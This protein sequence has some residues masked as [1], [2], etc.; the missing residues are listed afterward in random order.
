M[1]TILISGGGGY[2]GTQ[3]SQFLLKKHKVIIFDKFYFPWILK[4]KKKIKNN[5]N[6]SFIKKNISSAKL[7]DFK[8]VD[9]VCDLNGISNDPSSEL[10]PKH[11]WKLNFN[12]RVNFAKLSKKAKIKRYI[13]NSTCSVYGF[14]N[15]KVFESGAKRPISTYAKANLKAESFI[16]KMR[17]KNFRVN[18]LRNSTLYGFSNSMRLDLVINI[19]VLNILKKK[20]IKIDGDGNQYRPFISVNDVCNIY[21]LLI[22]RDKLPSFITNIVSFNSKIKDIA[23]KICKIL[24]SSKK[25]IIF[26]KNFSDK[27]NYN[28]GSKNFKKFF[29]QKFKFS[30]FELEIK[31]LSKNLRKYKIDFDKNTIRMKFYKDILN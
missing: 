26:K 10:N 18:S 24:K 14:S 11:T 30:K 15:K 13:F 28:V 8:G 12:D 9:I 1:K 19:F 16:Y 4:N 31:N 2:L 29:G 3:L 17:D 23:F 6:L 5:N 27:R 20:E 21:D 22:E 25:N 7:S